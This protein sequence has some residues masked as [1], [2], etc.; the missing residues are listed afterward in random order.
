[1]AQKYCVRKKTNVID[2]EKSKYYAV[3]VSSGLIGTKQLS[4]I[5]SD[6]CTVTE[7]DVLAVL[8]S[9]SSAMKTLL[10]DGYKVKL[11]DIGIFSQSVS[12]PGFDNPEDC[13]SKK[14][15]AKRICFTADSELKKILKQTDFVKVD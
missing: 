12:S 4:E 9:L 13:T 1:M 8:S 11:M 7:S 5:I 14:V 2:K 15:F 3:P 6:R 10:S